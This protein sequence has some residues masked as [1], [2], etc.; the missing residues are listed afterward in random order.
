MPW[1]R[2]K[3]LIMIADD[4]NLTRTLIA[5][6]LK[7]EKYSVIEAKNGNEVLSLFERVL[8]DI[9]LLNII[10]PEKDGLVT[11]RELREAVYGQHVPILMITVLD[12]DEAIEEAFAAGADDYIKKPING[13]VLK[14]RVRRLLETE[15]YRKKLEM[16]AARDFL[17]G[18]L[19]RRAFTERL[20]AELH[21]A[22]VK[23]HAIGLILCDLD[24]FK[25][26][27]DTFGHSVGDMVLK[28][29]VEVLN[30]RFGKYG[31]VGRHGGDEFIICLPKTTLVV[32]EILVQMTRMMIQEKSIMINDNKVSFSSSFGI[33]L[34]GH[35]KI[36]S[37]LADEDVV[38][39]LITLADNNLYL[40]KEDK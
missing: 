20:V 32:L 33:A 14:H 10:M 16:N 3:P 2:E 12:S 18:C 39:D 9:L 24:D 29:F 28:M 5:N 21:K 11:C 34:M 7:K 27:N 1:N 38:A 25:G 6:L 22:T 40:A 37:Y 31:F 8:P 19:N 13:L 4:D 17:T 30:Y 15:G 23:K 26:I 35:E 36:D